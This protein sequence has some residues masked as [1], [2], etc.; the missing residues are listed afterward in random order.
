MLEIISFTLGPAS[1]NAYLIADSESRQAVVVDPA[2]DGG[3]IATEAV[4]H[5]WT[6]SQVWVTH[7]HF[8]HIGGLAQLSESLGRSNLTV[9]LHA[10]DL[11]LWNAGGGGALFGF[12]IDPGPAPDLDLAAT[13]SLSLGGL[14]FEVR[15]TP[16]HTPG[17]CIFYCRAENVLF[18]GDLIFKGSVGRTDLPGGDWETLLASI[19]A[20]VF[21]LP[22]GTR[23]LS[24]HGPETTVGD[25]KA[26]N[27]FTDV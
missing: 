21:S 25:E 23:I 14:Q 13:R 26:Y 5:G 1:T 10:A 8:D 9:A 17:L 19:R 22:D 27:P 16:G 18:S 20:Q 6:I 11:P 7:A 3:L 15:H 12:Q 24:G 2:W 4:R